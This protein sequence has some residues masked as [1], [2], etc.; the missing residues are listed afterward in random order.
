[1]RWPPWTTPTTRSSGII[2]AEANVEV[3]L[4]S[5]DALARLHDDLVARGVVLAMAR[6][7]QDLLDD[8]EA[9][10]LDHAIGTEHFYPTLPT[11]VTAYLSWHAQTH[12]TTHPFGPV[13]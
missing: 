9:A 3:D 10:G 11:A 7:K 12:G 5:L 8:L 2:N 1:M 13:P 4:T 6:V